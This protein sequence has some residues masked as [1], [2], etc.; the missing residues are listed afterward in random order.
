MAFNPKKPHGQVFG[1]TQAKFYQNGKHYDS[2][3]N[4]FYMDGEEPE[5]DI[6]VL[7]EVVETVTDNTVQVDDGLE[8]L[9][10]KNLK[11]MVEEKGGD[12]VNKEEAIAFLR[13][14]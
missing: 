1:M 3:G 2:G 11:T 13:A 5:T 9:H 4:R 8:T 12:W 14:A 10:W 6:P 7:E